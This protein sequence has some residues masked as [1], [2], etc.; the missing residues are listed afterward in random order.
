VTLQFLFFD[1]EEA[2]KTWSS[3]DSLYGSRHLASKWSR[4]PYSYKGVTGN[5]LDRID[6]FMLLDLLGAANPKVTSS[7][8][9]T[10]VSCNYSPISSHPTHKTYFSFQVITKD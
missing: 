9:S 8:T 4:T 7:H 5:Q 10:E 3:T 2:F 1:G 6:V